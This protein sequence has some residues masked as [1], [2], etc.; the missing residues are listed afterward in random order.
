MDFD[1]YDGDYYIRGKETGKSLYCQY[2]W[3]PL[4]TIPFCVRIA[5]H[6][7]M[8]EGES[9]LDFGAA[10]GYSV[11]AFRMLGFDAWGV[12]ASKW[13]I[14]NCDPDVV[15]WMVH[16]TEP[17]GQY[18]Y[19]IAKDV[20]EHI[21]SPHLERAID[22]ILRNTKKAAFIVVPLSAEDGEQ[23]V[24]PEYEEDVTH[25]NRFTLDTWVSLCTRQGFCTTGV[26]RIPGIKENW[27]RPGYEEGN[28]ILH[29]R[30]ITDEDTD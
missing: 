2:R 4:L 12:D 13:A 20:L 22:G 29:V 14:D 26:Y 10:R 5:E 7:G 23:Y 11:R 17:P 8:Q 21:P 6:L 9:V 19:I 18:D 1:I 25:V 28:G 27:Y 3:K 24:I 30:S 16:G 15:P